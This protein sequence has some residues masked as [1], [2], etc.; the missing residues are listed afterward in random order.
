MKEGRQKKKRRGFALR[1]EVKQHGEE[2]IGTRATTG[3]GERKRREENK[4]HQKREMRELL[5]ALFITVMCGRYGCLSCGVRND[6]K[7]VSISVSIKKN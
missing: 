7:E 6:R 4:M 5:P 1:G 3:E 2:I